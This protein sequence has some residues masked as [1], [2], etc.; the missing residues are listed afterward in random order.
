MA[1][2]IFIWD[3]YISI[4]PIL[5]QIRIYYPIWDL[6]IGQKILFH[7]IVTALKMDKNNNL[8]ALSRTSSPKSLNQFRRA[9]MSKTFKKVSPTFDNFLTKTDST[10]IREVIYKCNC[11]GLCPFLSRDHVYCV[12]VPLPS[13]YLKRAMF[14]RV[15]QRFQIKPPFSICSAFSDV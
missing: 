13:R 5:I 10:K 1:D 14:Q 9:V 11:S 3:L 7:V 4:Y 15:R 6:L 12:T 8:K 2:V